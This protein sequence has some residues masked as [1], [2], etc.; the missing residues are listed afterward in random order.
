M[1]ISNN[2]STWSQTKP[3]GT[4]R[5]FLKPCSASSA[6][7]SS[8]VG[9]SHGSLDAPWLWALAALA[10]AAGAAAFAVFYAV[11]ALRLRASLAAAGTGSEAVK[12]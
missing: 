2:T 4:K 8:T 5:T 12:T 9:P 10:G 7:V 3:I 11:A 1:S 6:S